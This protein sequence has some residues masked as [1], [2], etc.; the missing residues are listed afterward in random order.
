M[1]PM[2]G[3]ICLVTGGSSGI[4]LATAWE[5]ACL[6]AEVVI[7]ARDRRRGKRAVKR[8]ISKSGSKKVE[9]LLADFSSLA[10]VRALAAEFCSA[11][12]QLDVLVNNAATV[13]LG[14]ELSEDGYEL[15]FAVNHLAP[16][17]LTNLLLPELAAGA[18]SRVVTVSSNVH[19]N[20]Q[21]DFDDLQMEQGY[22][23][24]GMYAL[25]KLA[26]VLF[27]YE[28]ARRLDG[29]GV[30]ANCLHPG[31]IHT[32]LNQNYMGRSSQGSASDVELVRGSATSVFLAASPEVEGVSGKYFTNQKE[33]R[34]SAES[35]DE[36][37][38]F[39]LW[40]ISAEMTGLET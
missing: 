37:T 6:G 5:L 35:Y 3:K 1:E 12:P 28:L 33:Q 29:S 14:R 27:T 2:D 22:S 32:N 4:G 20:A 36:D 30:S 34:S 15:Q 23:P 21:I 10:Q 8:I 19:Y 17:L 13:P 11:Y 16:F 18:P 7:T 26:N 9:M 40:Q 24:T 39:K 38:A 31:V 25:T